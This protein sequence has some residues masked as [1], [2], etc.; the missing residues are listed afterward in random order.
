[1]DSLSRDDLT[2]KSKVV[3]PWSIDVGSGILELS[4]C[5]SVGWRWRVGKKGEE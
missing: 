3:S 2:G 5:C 4:W 1:M